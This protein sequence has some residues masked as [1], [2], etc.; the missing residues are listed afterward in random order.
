LVNATT[1]TK[2]GKMTSLAMSLAALAC[3]SGGILL[4]MLFRPVLP[5]HHLSDEP[6]DV[7]KLGVGVIATLTALV[8]GLLTASAMNTFDTRNSELVQ[9]SSKII[10]LDRA[11]AAYGAETREA[12]DSLRR[13]L[14]S[15]I[16]TVWPEE[17]TRQRGAAAL[18]P[19]AAFESVQD[20]LLALSPRNDAQRWLQSRA[21]QINSD[22][23]GTGW[24]LRQQRT[25]SSLPKPFLVILV[26]WVTII[27]FCFSIL[28]P[29]NP[30]I[31][32]VLLIC[33][34]S[35]SSSLYLIEELDRPYQGLVKVSS[36]PLRNALAQIG[37]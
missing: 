29:R 1:T 15:A 28:S 17:K 32:I 13:G 11:M 18:G 25:A 21:L 20:K 5:D 30:T 7:V 16:D 37:R 19:S 33:A 24:L 12:R 23:E 34:V 31:V 2:E 22:I 9:T 36:D 14:T 4:G 26:C 27:F 35:V 8:L 6:K 10:L 3:M